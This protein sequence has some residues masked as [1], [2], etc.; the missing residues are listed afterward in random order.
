MPGLAADMCA[1]AIPPLI[2]RHVSP[3]G[4]MGTTRL[5]ADIVSL[6]QAGQTNLCWLN[7]PFTRIYAL[8]TS[9]GL[10]S[11]RCWTYTRDCF[12]CL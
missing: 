7:G 9:T 12:E 11:G 5:H 2:E 1:D 3:V 10:A 4:S 8:R 6:L